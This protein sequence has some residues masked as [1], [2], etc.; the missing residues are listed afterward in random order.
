MFVDSAHLSNGCVVDFYHTNSSSA[1]TS[2]LSYNFGDGTTVNTSTSPSN[3]SVTTHTYTSSGWYNVCLTVWDSSFCQNAYCDSI[4]VNCGGSQNCS[5]N[6][7]HTTQNCNVSFVSTVNPASSGWNYYWNFGDGGTSNQANPSHTYS[8]NGTYNVCLTAWNN[9]TQ[10]SDT[11]C[12]PIQITNCGSSSNC[13]IM[14][15]SFDSACY[16]YFIPTATPSNPNYNYQW[17]FGDGNSSTQQYPVHQYSTPGLYYTCVTIWDNST[18]CQATYCDTISVNC[19]P[20]SINEM[21][22]LKDFK[23][24]P[25]P[26]NDRINLN[27][28][29]TQSEKVSIT[30]TDVSGRVIDIILENQYLSSGNRTIEYNLNK[31]NSGIYFVNTIVGSEISVHKFIK[32]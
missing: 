3:T 31:L 22:N 24:Y 19:V 8:S 16:T 10:C 2:H 21:N 29:L 13:Q 1:F 4:Y 12:L 7:T 14:F 20:N 23:L 32:H 15:T 17:S 5:V 6:W 26:A 11:L 30:I 18:S 25:N 28:S 9:L 27:F